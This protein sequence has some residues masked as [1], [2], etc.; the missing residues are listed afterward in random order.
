[1]R[2][3][4]MDIKMTSQET[5]DYTVIGSRLLRGGNCADYSVKNVTSPMQV[6]RP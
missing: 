4:N 1:M 2:N 5:L 6:K 3:W